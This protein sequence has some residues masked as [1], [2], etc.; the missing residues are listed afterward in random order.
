M[1]HGG[2]L[3]FVTSLRPDAEFVPDG[4][5]RSRFQVTEEDARRLGMQIP[6]DGPDAKEF[7]EPVADKMVRRPST[8]RRRP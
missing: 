7:H 4:D 6:A 1:S 2:R 5:V 3:Y 8:K